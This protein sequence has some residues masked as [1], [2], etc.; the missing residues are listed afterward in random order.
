RTALSIRPK[1]P[2]ARV[3]ARTVSGAGLLAARS[4]DE[5]VPPT[6]PLEQLRCH[7]VVR[8]DRRR[9]ADR[10]R[11]SARKLRCR[12][13]RACSMRIRFLVRS[14]LESGVNSMKLPAISSRLTPQTDLADS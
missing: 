2:G 5:T 4:G 10:V 11:Q 13:D 9:Q 8:C 7:A 6:D 14:S 3:R 1:W 12:P